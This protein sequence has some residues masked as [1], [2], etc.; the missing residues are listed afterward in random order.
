RR[1]S[2]G[3][4]ED[5]VNKPYRPIAA[6]LVTREGAWV[7]LLLGMYLYTL[8]GWWQGVLV[9]ALAWQAMALF[10]NLGASRHWLWK[11]FMMTTGG[12]V[13]LYAAWE[14]VTPITP[15][16]SAYILL[17]C[18]PICLM[19]SCQDLRDVE[20]DKLMNRRTFPMVFGDRFT[21]WEVAIS[22]AMFP[23]AAFFV[24]RFYFGLTP[25]VMVTLAVAVLSC[26]NIAVRV[27]LLRNKEADH[28]TYMWF[29][30]WYCFMLAAGFFVLM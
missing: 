22:S 15:E 1:Q 25:L 2:V 20:G 30:Y 5:R 6:G 10:L 28:R 23:V 29:T 11:N 24:L 26:A 18:M 27:L 13:Q 8:I 19:V 4:E 9:W 21:R 7:R 14:M 12:I 17:I 3:V 16:A